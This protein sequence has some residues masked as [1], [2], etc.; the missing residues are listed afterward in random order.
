M[1]S[2][3]EIRLFFE[4]LRRYSVAWTRHVGIG[5]NQILGIYET[6]VF[7]LKPNRPTIALLLLLSLERCWQALAE[8]ASNTGMKR[9]SNTGMKSGKEA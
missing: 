6:E 4:N 2:A 3:E 9:A 7:R 5:R 8:G 1:C